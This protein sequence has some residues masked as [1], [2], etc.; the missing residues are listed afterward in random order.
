[1]RPNK[2]VETVAALKRAKECFNY[3][4]STGTFVR[5]S[6]GK[7]VGS[8]HHSG[9]LHIW[10]EGRHFLAH[11]LAWAFV[12]NR[13]P[14]QQIDHINHERS[15]NRIGNLREASHG[16]NTRNSKIYR[17]NHSGFRGVSW[18]SQSKA[19]VA[20]AN[21]RGRVHYLGLYKTAK[22]A[23]AAYC[24]FARSHYEGFASV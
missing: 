19:F 11:R 14:Q 7:I 16:Q 4:S 5:R 2:R 23:H 1:M 13:W 6:S 9:Y 20:Q 12:H 17:T 10:F 3:D 22:Q 8:V 15:D 18:H 21:F 24:I